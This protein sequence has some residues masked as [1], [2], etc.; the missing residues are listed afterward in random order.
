MIYELRTYTAMPGKLPAVLRRFETATLSLFKKHGFRH[1]PL[2][3]VAVGE[4]NLQV[5]Y[6]LEWESMAERDKAWLA[7]R[8]D[9]DWHKAL[10]DSEKDG[11]IVE[12]IGNELLQAAP[13][14]VKPAQ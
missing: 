5:K 1:G 11:P 6:I 3:T 8:G 14:S 7:F 2:L 10:A 12:K 13:F 4:S 9:A